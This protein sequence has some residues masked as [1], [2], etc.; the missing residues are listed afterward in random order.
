MYHMRIIHLK[1]LLQKHG[2]NIHRLA[3][4][5]GLGRTTLYRLQN[6]KL[7]SYDWVTL[8]IICKG[9]GLQSMNELIE[10]KPDKKI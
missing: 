4:E 9:L 7:K 5:T 10:Y 8:E 6:D 3:K 1:E 2:T